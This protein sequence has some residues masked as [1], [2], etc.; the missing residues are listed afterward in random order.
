[1]RRWEWDE[2]EVA[3]EPVETPAFTLAGYRHTRTGIL[4]SARFG[5]TYPGEGYVP[6]FT[7]GPSVVA[8]LIT[9]LIALAEDRSEA[10]GARSNAF[11]WHKLQA[12]IALGQFV[13]AGGELP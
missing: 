3:A 12:Q 11:M 10:L 1:M 8:P 13:E 5:Y 9:A 7:G 2:D 6:V 4:R